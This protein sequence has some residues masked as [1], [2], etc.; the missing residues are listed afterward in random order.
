MWAYEMSGPYDEYGATRE[1][2][3]AEEP[4]SVTGHTPTTMETYT[5]RFVDAVDLKREDIDLKDIAH[6]LSL[7]CRFGGH[8]KRFYSVAH[9]SILCHD[10][11]LRRGFS[12]DVAVLALLHDIGEAYWH[13]LGRPLKVAE[14]M[15]A[16][17]KYLDKAQMVAERALGV[18]SKTMIRGLLFLIEPHWI[19]KDFDDAV[20][21]AEA[22]WLM[23]SGGKHWT[24]LD[25]VSVAVVPWWKWWWYRFP[26][27]AERGFVCRYQK[28]LRTVDDN[29]SGLCVTYAMMNG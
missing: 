3:M 15:E 16:Y 28:W 5:G 6:S 26:R 1:N 4:P 14:G 9:H 25:G 20:L 8:C 11:A 27:R 29:Y 24:A 23:P 13:D 12:R 17:L 19:I 22:A 18:N 2:N 10:E 21:K 7:I